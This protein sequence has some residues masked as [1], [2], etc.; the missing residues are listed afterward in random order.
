[1][2]GRKLSELVALGLPALDLKV[3]KFGG[4]SAWLTARF[5]RVACLSPDSQAAV[6]EVLTVLSFSPVGRSA[7]TAEGARMC[8]RRRGTPGV[9]LFG[10]QWDHLGEVR[11]RDDLPWLGSSVAYRADVAA[12]DEVRQPQPLIVPFPYVIDLERRCDAA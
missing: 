2:P 11:L 12:C 9:A 5:G 4:S 1:M 8:P 10:I 3:D 7:D 6:A